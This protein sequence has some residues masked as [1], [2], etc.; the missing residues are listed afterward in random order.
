MSCIATF[1]TIRY[2][3]GTP[4]RIELAGGLYHVTSRSDLKKGS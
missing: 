4:L 3:H 1:L 2:A